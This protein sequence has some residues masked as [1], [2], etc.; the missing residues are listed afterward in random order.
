MAKTIIN[1]DKVQA[2]YAGNIETVR[3]SAEL[4]NGM[5][6]NLG[7]LVNGER[8][9]YNVATP[10][11]ATLGSEELLLIASPEVMYESG[12]NLADFSIP[13]GKEARAYHLTIGDVFT[14]TDDGFDGTSAIGKYLIPQNGSLKLV[15]ADDLSGATRFAAKII[16]KGTLGFNGTAATTVR[17]VKC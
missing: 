13:A 6:C 12:K 11:T 2:I 16:E 8:E 7:A 15:V 1:L 10:A 4:Q 17:V 5:V 9:V 14:I 3:H